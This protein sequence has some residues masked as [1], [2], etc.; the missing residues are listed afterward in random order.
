MLKDRSKNYMFMIKLKPILP[1][2]LK[3]CMGFFFVFSENF[4]VIIKKKIFLYKLTLG[5]N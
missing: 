1:F 4:K 5:F 2:I 3:G